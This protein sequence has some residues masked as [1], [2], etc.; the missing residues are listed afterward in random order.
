M[1]HSVKENGHYVAY[2][3]K[4]L[5]VKVFDVEYR[6]AP[7]AKQLQMVGDFYHAL[8][9]VYNN[10][11]KLGVDKDKIIIQG[12]SGGAYVVNST[13]S[14]LALKNESGMAKLYISEQ[15]VVPEWFLN[16]ENDKDLDPLVAICKYDNIP[17][18]RFTADDVEKQLKAKDPIQFAT[19]AEDAVL[20]KWPPTVVITSEFDNF[21]PPMKEL[22]ER[23]K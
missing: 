8:K 12:C 1:A 2:F 17:L 21:C 22:S 16:H 11:E 14:M 23:L 3:S 13:C 9:Y 19:I 15:A 10:A 6:L 7:E 4:T 5:G 18:A 20:Q